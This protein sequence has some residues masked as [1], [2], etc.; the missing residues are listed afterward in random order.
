MNQKGITLV[1]I[2]ISLGLSVF[3]FTALIGAFLGVKSLNDISKTYLQGSLIIR[4]Q[5]EALKGTAFGLIADANVQTAYDAGPDATW[6]TV[7]DLMGTLTT[8]VQDAADFDAD[9]VTAETDISVDGNASN[10]GVA[11][12]VRVAFTWNQ[13]V[14]GNNRDFTLTADT[15]IA[16]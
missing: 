5:M 13:R 14:L 4:G 1:E 15:I 12:P 10:D 16:A 11:L 3:V 6:G 7:D 9:G 8:M 2:I